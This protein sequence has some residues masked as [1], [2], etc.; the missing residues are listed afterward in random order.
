[1]VNQWTLQR[2]IQMLRDMATDFPRTA[3]DW[4][5]IADRLR[6]EANSFTPQGRG[7]KER[8]QKTILPKFKNQNTEALKRSGT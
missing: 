2:D 4:Q 8:W 6:D 3:A 1:M 5:L 7:V